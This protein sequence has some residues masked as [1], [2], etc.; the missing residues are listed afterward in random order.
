MKK[1]VV[2][3]W[4]FKCIKNV[5]DVKLIRNLLW[6]LWM[7]LLLSLLGYPIVLLFYHLSQRKPLCGLYQKSK[8]V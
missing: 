4:T 2:I 3:L 5:K 7:S 8:H 1:A 6:N